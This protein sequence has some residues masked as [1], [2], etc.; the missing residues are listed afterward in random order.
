MHT[1]DVRVAKG[2]LGSSTRV[3]LRQ[4]VNLK[5]HRAEATVKAPSDH[6]LSCP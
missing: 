4:R 1:G 6:V 2:N 5:C 3:I